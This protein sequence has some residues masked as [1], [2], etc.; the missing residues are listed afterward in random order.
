MTVAECYRFALTD[1]SVNLCMMGSRTA[2][3]MEQGLTALE[4]GSLPA[5]EMDRARRIGD[6]VH[7]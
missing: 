5:W 7:G 3:E 2:L 1:P 4:E 6:F